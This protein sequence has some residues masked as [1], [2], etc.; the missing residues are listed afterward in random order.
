MTDGTEGLSQILSGKFRCPGWSSD[1]RKGKMRLPTLNK[2]DLV[3]VY[4]INM[5][6]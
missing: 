6:E 2:S 5:H 4:T 1:T 3:A